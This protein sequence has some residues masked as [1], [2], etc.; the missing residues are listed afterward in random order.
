MEKEITGIFEAS[1][2]NGSSSRVITFEVIT[3]AV[4]MVILV[5]ITGCWISIETKTIA[6]LLGSASSAGILF[7]TIAGPTLAWMYSQ[8]KQEIKNNE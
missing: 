6:P 5:V 1:P 4:I 3:A 7:V 8:K 2:G